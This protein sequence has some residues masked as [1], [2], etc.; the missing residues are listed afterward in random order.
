MVFTENES[1]DD[2]PLAKVAKK[3]GVDEDSH[4]NLGVAE[5][6]VDSVLERP[7]KTVQVAENSKPEIPAAKFDIFFEYE[8]PRNRSGCFYILEEFLAKFLNVEIMDE[9]LRGMFFILSPWKNIC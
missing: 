8:W 2:I 3:I 7:M 6:S 4:S 9:R 5:E 1:E